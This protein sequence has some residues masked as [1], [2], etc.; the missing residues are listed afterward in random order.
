MGKD[1][2]RE[3]HPPRGT[4]ERRAGPAKAVGLGGECVQGG[5]VLK[6]KRKR[7]PEP[8]SLLLVHTAEEESRLV[9][10]STEG[11]L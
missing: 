2:P 9:C 1:A 6:G 4:R 7:W 11:I 5:G 8:R 3:E 10:V